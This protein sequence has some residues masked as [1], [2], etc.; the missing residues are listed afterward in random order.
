MSCQ[1]EATHCEILIPKLPLPKQKG[2][3]QLKNKL[4]HAVI[5]CQ[6]LLFR[7]VDKWLK[8]NILKLLLIVEHKLTQSVIVLHVNNNA[9][10]GTQVEQKEHTE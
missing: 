2:V 8:Q 4:V 3:I 1:H 10:T 9:T 7:R 5:D 6:T